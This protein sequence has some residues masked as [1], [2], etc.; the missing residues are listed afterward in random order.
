[1]PVETNQHTDTNEV[2]ASC[3]SEIFFYLGIISHFELR[4]YFSYIYYILIGSEY[5][6]G[7]SCHKPVRLN[8]M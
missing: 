1:M 4:E 7:I 2:L 8:N 3:T 6:N 5:E